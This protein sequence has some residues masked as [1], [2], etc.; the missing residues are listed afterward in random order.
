MYHFQTWLLGLCR[1]YRLQLLSISM[2]F[3]GLDIS[4]STLG[5]E[6]SGCYHACD[7]ALSAWAGRGVSFTRCAQA[8]EHGG[9]LPP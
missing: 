3:V 1:W 7:S 5:Q 8:G 4:V 2:A 6:K 9:F